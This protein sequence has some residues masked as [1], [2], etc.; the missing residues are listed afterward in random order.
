MS[1]TRP[2]TPADTPC[3]H[4]HSH[5]QPHTCMTSRRVVAF[6]QSL[7]SSRH[8]MMY[9]FCSIFCRTMASTC[10]ALFCSVV[11][12]LPGAAE[13]RPAGSQTGEEPG[14]RNVGLG[15]VKL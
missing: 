1:E 14:E 6:D 12:R 3:R 8:R 9:S 7:L 15:W 5:S 10:R 11:L 2:S 4:P 13:M